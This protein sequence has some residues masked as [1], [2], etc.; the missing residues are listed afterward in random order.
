MSYAT[1]LTAALRTA[2]SAKQVLRTPGKGGK[3]KKRS[4][5]QALEE[6]P[7]LA[8]SAPMAQNKPSNWGIFEPIHNF[9]P[10][11]DTIESLFSAQVIIAVLGA[12]LVYAWFF[13]G[14]ATALSGPNQWTS[15]QRQV[16]YEEIWRREES[17]L[18]SW[19]ED[20]VALDRVH[21]TTASGPK[22]W[23]TGGGASGSGSDTQQPLGV[24]DMPA[25][26]IDEALRVTELRLQE[27]KE[28]VDRERRLASTK[29]AKEQA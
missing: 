9:V 8:P 28:A 21:V 20:R 11:A 14:S 12:L 2:V 16:A 24:K 13:R 1:A 10:F 15:T 7:V 22:S 17:E 18:W 6:A 19:L 23:S 4:K 27:L 25:R 5:T 3:G 29:S 26:E